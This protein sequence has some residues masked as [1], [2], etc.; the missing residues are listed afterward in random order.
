MRKIL[1][2]L[3]SLT[4][5]SFTTGCM[6]RIIIEE[7]SLA[8][9]VGI[10]LDEKNNLVLSISSPV[11]SEEAKVKEE[12]YITKAYTLRES[13]EEVDKTF[14][15]L[16]TGGKTQAV[17]I[18]KRVMEHQG[19]FKLLEPF[20]RDA[21]NT[22]NARIVMVDGIAHQIITLQPKDKPRLSLYLAK[23]I[24]KDNL[25]NMN[26]KIT[27]EDLRRDNYEN[28][29][30]ASVT[31]LRKDGKILV[32]GTALLDELGRYKL[33]IGPDENKLLHILQNNIK[34]EFSFTFRDA[35]R[36]KGE[37]FP[38]DAYSFSAGSISVKTKTGY[39]DD[40]FTF[41]IAVDMRVA[42][43]ERFFPLDILKEGD[44]LEREMEREFEKRFKKFIGKIQAA[45]IDP[46][47]LGIHARAYQYDHY[48]PVQ[49]KW[50]EALSKAD[51]NV[52]VKTVI[53]SMGT[54]K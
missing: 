28:G 19:W 4:L 10:D 18:G 35:N 37:I 9:L 53:T 50:G 29:I 52:K 20:L 8:L 33:S 51:V 5:I 17:L 36:P 34:G 15:A 45:K 25:R 23:L 24:D 47:G 22:V 49:N 6:D 1:P 39:Q 31:E 7:V 48:K 13:R 32:T 16:T 44:K 14:L 40:K 11:F 54:T 46:I 21:K 26:V 30:T 43:T 38:D 2:L 27:L 41:D 3:L 12:V 42:L